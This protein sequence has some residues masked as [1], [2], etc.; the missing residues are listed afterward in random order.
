MEISINS[1]YFKECVPDVIKNMNLKVF[2]M[3]SWSNERKQIKWYE[4]CKCECKLNASVCN[5]KKSWN[6]DK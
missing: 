3:I 4:S 2:N 5:D 6:K 1:P